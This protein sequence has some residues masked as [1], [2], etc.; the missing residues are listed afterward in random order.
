MDHMETSIQHEL[1]GCKGLIFY[2]NVAVLLD[3]VNARG[4]PL[5]VLAPNIPL[6]NFVTKQIIKVKVK[7][8]ILKPLENGETAY[9]K[10]CKDRYMDKSKKLSATISKVKL[11]A[12]AAQFNLEKVNTDIDSIKAATSIKD[13]ASAQRD[14][15][16]ATL[17]GISPR[18]LYAHDLLQ[19]SPLFFGEFTTKPDKAQLIAELEK[20]SS[21]S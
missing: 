8:R 21:T 1:G 11:P 16:I 15:E 2:R 17:C 20:K 7:A 10:I 19:Y 3:F 6:Y 5:L 12:F 14:A 13:I 9:Q 18:E 4:N